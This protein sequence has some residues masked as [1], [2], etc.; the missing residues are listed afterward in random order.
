MKKILIG[1]LLLGSMY[2]LGSPY[3][4]LKQIQS[5]VAYGDTDALIP[6]VDFYSLEKSLE[7]SVELTL[8]EGEKMLA[9]DVWVSTGLEVTKM[10]IG[11]ELFDAGAEI[12]EE[13]RADVVDE[14]VGEMISPNHLLKILDS[15]VL[16]TFFGDDDVENAPNS[17]NGLGITKLE[18]PGP[19][20]R[21]D[22]FNKFVVTFATDLCPE[23]HLTLERR[24]LD[25][26]VTG[27][28][29]AGAEC[30]R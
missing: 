18:V 9:E 8:R 26:V 21:Y 5:T 14:I 27:M 10:L 16:L 7:T 17:Q 15:G 13:A 30:W 11:E 20:V 12:Y 28:S 24:G 1:I 19:S 29:F 3:L 2:L 22:G 23:S 25:W 6:S 4:K